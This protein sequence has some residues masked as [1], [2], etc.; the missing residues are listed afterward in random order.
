MSDLIPGN[1]RELRERLSRVLANRRDYRQVVEEIAAKRRYVVFFGVGNIFHGIVQAWRRHLGRTIDYCCD[2]DS[3]KWGQEFCGITCISPGRLLEIKD[4]CAIFVTVGSFRPLYRSLI[5]SGCSSVN[6]VHRYDL[7]AAEFLADQDQQELVTNLCRTY[8]LLADRQ[9][10]RV[11]LAIVDRVLEGRNDPETM[12]R[13]CS[14][15]EYFPEDI[16]RL[17]DHE[18]F[19]DAGAFDGDTVRDFVARTQARFDKIFAFELDNRNFQRLQEHTGKLPNHRRIEV[20][21]LGIWDSTGDISYSFESSQSTVGRGEGR[22]RVVR[23]DDVLENEQVSLIKMDIEGAELRAL[24]GTGTIIRTRKPRLAICVYHDFRHLWEVP[25]L[26]REL[27]PEYKIYL[28]HHTE[29]AYE[30]VCYAVA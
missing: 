22:G 25:L 2:G 11:F 8:D 5:E 20:F 7:A 9:S 24:R 23:L 17:S 4:D 6:V 28:R 13:V 27:V 21:N 16:I 30:T 3:S 15:D 18:C 12:A 19:V 29:L 26:L 10:A 14:G 1:D